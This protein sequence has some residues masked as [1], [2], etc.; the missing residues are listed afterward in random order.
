MLSAA[1]TKTDQ[2]RAAR[3]V[4]AW[5][6]GDKQA[7]DLVLG[8]VIE[9]GGE[10][11]L[12]FSLTSFAAQLVDQVPGGNTGALEKALLRLLDVDQGSNEC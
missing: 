9:S 7:L 3:A 12:I 2:A 10:A 6:N 5:R 8:E 4:L 1:V 11:G